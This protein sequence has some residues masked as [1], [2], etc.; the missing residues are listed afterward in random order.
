MG[1]VEYDL[2]KRRGEEGMGGK[3]DQREKDRVSETEGLNTLYPS[4]A[5]SNLCTPLKKK[6]R[7]R[8]SMMCTA[9]S[10]KSCSNHAV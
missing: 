5:I 9:C 7:R 2:K 4:S 6:K 1:N 3:S 10:W 8:K